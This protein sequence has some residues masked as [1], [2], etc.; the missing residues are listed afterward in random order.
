MII[1]AK[2]MQGNKVVVLLVLLL[3]SFGTKAELKLPSL[4]S[5]HMVLQRNVPIPIWGW[6]KA[7]EPVSVTFKDKTYKAT[8]DSKADGN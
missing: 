6:A 7:G 2:T 5:D 4:V 3:F 1:Q 8:A